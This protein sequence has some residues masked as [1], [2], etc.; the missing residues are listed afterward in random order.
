MTDEGRNI[1]HLKY[2]L[3]QTRKKCTSSLFASCQK[4][5]S[6]LGKLFHFKSQHSNFSLHLYLSTFSPLYLFLFSQTSRLF[7]DDDQSDDRMRERMKKINL[8]KCCKVLTGTSEVRMII[9]ERR[10]ISRSPIKIFCIF[11]R[12]SLSNRFESSALIPC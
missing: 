4:S 7:D 8:E 10:F 1:I 5:V 9:H 12:L 2:E 3:I 11:Q 6:I